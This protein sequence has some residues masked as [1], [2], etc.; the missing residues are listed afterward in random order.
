MVHLGSKHRKTKKLTGK[1][2]ETYTKLY[3][4]TDTVIF[5]SPLNIPLRTLRYDMISLGKMKIHADKWD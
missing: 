1:T 3:Q 2:D 4:E 5:I